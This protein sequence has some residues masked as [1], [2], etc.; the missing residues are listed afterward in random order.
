[1]CVVR[2][3]VD[4]ETAAR[5]CLPGVCSARLSGPRRQN[6]ELP[7]V[8]RAWAEERTLSGAAQRVGSKSNC[9]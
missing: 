1:M 7:G 8:L 6:L 3:H 2:N 5:F 4:Q 9:V